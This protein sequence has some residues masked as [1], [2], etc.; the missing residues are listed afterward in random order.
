MRHST[1]VTCK[2]LNRR[3]GGRD[4]MGNGESKEKE[5]ANDLVPMSIDN[6]CTLQ[7]IFCALLRA[8]LD[9]PCAVRLHDMF[10]LKGEGERED[11]EVRCRAEHRF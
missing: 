2:C 7:S 1:N 5:L 3:T 10:V 4:D 8:E 9:M 6:S 11:V